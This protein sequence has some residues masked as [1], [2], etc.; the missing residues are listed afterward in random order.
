MRDGSWEAWR[1]IRAVESGVLGPPRRGRLKVGGGEE[2]AEILAAHLRQALQ[3][4]EG[5]GRLHTLAK[6]LL[7]LGNSMA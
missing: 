3:V 2:R 1:E 5:Q 6:A 7:N 4:G